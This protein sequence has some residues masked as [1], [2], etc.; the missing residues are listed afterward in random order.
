MTSNDF[1]QWMLRSAESDDGPSAERRRRNRAAVMN[2]AGIAGA[3]SIAA[4]SAK[5]VLA[6]APTTK[7]ASVT[8]AGALTKAGAMAALSL[9]CAGG[10]YSRGAAPVVA[11]SAAPTTVL[12]ASSAPRGV[13][14]STRPPSTTGEIPPTDP[15]S[16]ASASSAASPQTT[17][18]RKTGAVH[19]TLDPLVVE[20]GLL[21]AART[22]VEAGDIS[23]ATSKLDEHRAHFPHGQLSN[24]ASLLRIEVARLHRS[25]D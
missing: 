20:T 4:T 1:E 7:T 8:A 11:P 2:A 3:A 15:A 18:G 22:C 25:A 23:C 24:E 6:A 17:R 13:P 12:P 19:P 14:Q 16:P 21:E 9:V 10:I 5:T